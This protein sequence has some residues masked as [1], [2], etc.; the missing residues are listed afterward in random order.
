[1][2]IIAHLEA[3]LGEELQM[4]RFANPPTSIPE[5]RCEQV[6]RRSLFEMHRYSDGLLCC[7]SL[8]RKGWLLVIITTQFRVLLANVDLQSR[9]VGHYDWCSSATD[10]FGAHLSP[11]VLCPH[12][13]CVLQQA[14]KFDDIDFSDQVRIEVRGVR[15]IGENPVLATLDFEVRWMYRRR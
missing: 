4:T 12:R 3:L 7:V 5:L 1:M 10:P 9:D 13:C 11:A 8:K 15:K 6:Q 14:V 2:Y